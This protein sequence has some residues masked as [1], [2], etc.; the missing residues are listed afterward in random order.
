[1]KFYLEPKLHKIEIAFESRGPSFN[2]K[3]RAFIYRV[4]IQGTEKGGAVECKTCD[5]GS[6]ANAKLYMCTKC[7]KGFQPDAQQKECEQCP[8]G[9][10]NPFKGGVC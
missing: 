10:Y 4:M 9:T 5:E 7:E 8:E 2:Y 6:I 3:A 1:M